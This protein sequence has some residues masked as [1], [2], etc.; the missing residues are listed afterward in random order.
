M[1]PLFVFSF[2]KKKIIMKKQ[3]F[4]SIFWFTGRKWINNFKISFPRV[5]GNETPICVDW[6]TKSEPVT[7]SVVPKF[8][9]TK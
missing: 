6:S 7:S 5:G 1:A 9:S 4:G 8:C 2:V 3:D